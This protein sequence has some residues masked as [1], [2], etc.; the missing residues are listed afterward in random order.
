VPGSPTPEPHR[1]SGKLR[2]REW[3]PGC[4]RSTLALMRPRRGPEYRSAMRPDVRGR[5]L[6]DAGR[7]RATTL[8]RRMSVNLSL[9]A[10]ISSMTLPVFATASS[11]SRPRP[12]RLTCTPRT[13]T[14]CSKAP[15]DTHRHDEPNADV[16]DQSP[17]G[18]RDGREKDE[19]TVVAW[20]KRTRAARRDQEGCAGATDGDP[21]RPDRHERG[22]TSSG[23]SR[24]TVKIER[25]AR[26]AG[27]DAQHATS[28]GPNAD[29]PA[30]SCVDLDV[31]GPCGQRDPRRRGNVLCQ[32]AAEHQERP[33]DD[34]ADHCAITVYV[35]EAE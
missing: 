28:R 27:L 4:L 7:R 35:T 12:R 20:A 10:S 22:G 13:V 11:M 19:S 3:P 31:R 23:D 25:V 6:R 2:A 33:S 5:S 24:A 15:R 8:P 34:G 1:R 17:G 29:D 32:R 30:A 16:H 9:T 18:R 21:L 14:R 26:Y